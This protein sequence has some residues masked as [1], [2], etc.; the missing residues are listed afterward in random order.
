MA[1]KRVTPGKTDTTLVTGKQKE[2]KDLDLTFSAK[3]GSLNEDGVQQGDLYKKTDAAAVIQSVE[4]ILLTNRLEKPFNPTYGANLRA[5]LF[6][7]V[8]TYSERIIR[9]QIIN[10]L[11]RDEPRVTRLTSMTDSKTSSTATTTPWRTSSTTP[12]RRSTDT[13]RRHRSSMSLTC[14]PSWPGRLPTSSPM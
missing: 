3:P 7:M 10:A 14:S 6:D 5:M 1:L 9:N 4:N 2:Y 11:Q 8:E 12:T 13:A